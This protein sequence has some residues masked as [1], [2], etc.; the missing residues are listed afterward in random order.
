MT[1]KNVFV[2]GLDAFSR[3]MLQRLPQAADCEFHVALEMDDI[4]HVNEYDIDALIDKAVDAM[5]SVPGGPAAIVSFYDFPGTLLVPILARH[6]DLPGPSVEAVLGC[7]NKYWSRLEQQKVIPEYIPRFRAFD[8]FDDNTYHKL[9]M[10]PPFWIKPI[11]SFRSM[12]AF[13]INGPRQFMQAMDVARKEVGLI[14][15]PFKQLMQRFDVP[16]ELANMS[17]SFIAESPIGGAQCTLEGYVYNGTVRVYGVVDSVRE[18]NTSS[19]SRYQYPSMLPLEVQHRMIDVVRA[20]VTQIGLDNGPFNAEFFY[21]QTS[22]HVWLLEIN[23][24]VSQSHANIFEKVHGVS[25]F[26]IM[27]D[28]ALGRKPQTL[29]RKGDFNIAAKFFVRSFER[30]RVARIPKQES[31]ARL[32]D[33]QPGTVVKLLVEPGD[34]LSTLE[35]QDAYSFELANVFIGGRDE[36]DLLDKY[37]LLMTAM[38]FDVEKEERTPA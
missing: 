22:D 28:L 18:Q 16:D 11:K 4:R 3:E 25:H 36:E 5:Q 37:D 33:R 27:L 34:D 2:I 38:Q 1:R 26:S 9:D 29:D 32:L 12:L 13:S 19:F 6:F 15:V 10:L 30:G 7:E 24:R 20:A 8:P 31:L 35:G 21:D 23:P 17:E 14:D